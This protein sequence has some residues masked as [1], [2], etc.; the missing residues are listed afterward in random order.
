[1]NEKVQDI[2]AVQDTQSFLMTEFHSSHKLARRVS[3]L[4]G[5]SSGAFRTSCI[6]RL[7]YVV[8]RVLLD[9][10]SRYEVVGP[11]LV[12]LTYVMNKLNH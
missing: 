12:D 3:D 10:S 6:R 8:I 9:M 1:M 2:Y 5:P 4:T 11:K 7:W